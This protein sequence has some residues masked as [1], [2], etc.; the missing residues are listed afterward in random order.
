MP[1]P[2]YCT[3]AQAVPAVPPTSL[4]LSGASEDYTHLRPMTLKKDGKIQDMR[5][6]VF[7]KYVLKNREL[8]SHQG[9][10]M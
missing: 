2:I 6:K 9:I 7:E 10:E 4:I 5:R 3:P 8:Y 1:F